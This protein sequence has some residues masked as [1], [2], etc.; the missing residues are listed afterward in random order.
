MSSSRKILKLDFLSSYT[1]IKIKWIKARENKG[2]TIRYW[3]RPSGCKQ[4]GNVSGFN[5]KK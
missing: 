5:N 4:E 3:Y 1:I 2:V